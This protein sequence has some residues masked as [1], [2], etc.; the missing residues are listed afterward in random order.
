MHL[1]FALLLVFTASTTWAASEQTVREE[2][3]SAPGGQLVVDVDFGTVNLS[4][5][6]DAKVSVEAMRKIDMGDEAREK[7]YLSETPILVAKEG[8]TITVRARRRNGERSYSN[9]SGNVSLD[10]R[11]TVRVP[12]NFSAD[13]RTRGGGVSVDGITGDI[14]ADTS[15]GKMKFAQL[16]GTLDARTSGGS[17]ALD[18]C[19]GPLKIS[20][21]GGAIDAKNGGGS[22]DARTSGGSIVVRDFNGD[23]DVKTSGGKLSFEN[24]K[25]TING[26]TSAGSIDAAL[27]DP[28]P[29]DVTL[30]TSAGSIDLSLSAKAAVNVDAK[31]SLGNIRT[32]IPMLATKSGDDRL[33][34]TLNG[35]GKSLNL[36]A[37][38]GSITIR[39][40]SS[41]TA[42]R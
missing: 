30:H 14:K 21:S 34:G 33:L 26:K 32:E 40:T 31:S 29:G 17:I 24:I 1:R 15:G 3:D 20:T 37:S 23:T 11:Y 19:E 25:G 38:V 12:K 28:V 2:F 10:A 36:K 7:E 22:L 35:G 13:L 5:G 39:P 16:R 8:N 18:G 4:A 41:P 6:P 27:S 42:A 9:W